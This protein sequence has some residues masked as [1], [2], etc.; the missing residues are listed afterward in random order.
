MS[1]SSRNIIAASGEICS[2]LAKSLIVFFPF[3][4]ATFVSAPVPPLFSL[5]SPHDLFSPPYFRRAGFESEG[6]VG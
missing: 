6:V 4:S 3:L 5:F 1:N 2:R